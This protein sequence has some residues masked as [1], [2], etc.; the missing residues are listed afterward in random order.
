MELECTCKCTKSALN[1]SDK[2]I[3]V[4]L[5]V[6]CKYKIWVVKST[7]TQNEYKKAVWH[8]LIDRGWNT[9]NLA[10]AVSEKTGLFCDTSY[11]SKILSGERSAPKIRAAICEILEMK[12]ES[13]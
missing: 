4:H 2:L 13:K 10:E 9:A 8:K 11:I 1:S 7:E 5:R 3:I 12:E 6:L